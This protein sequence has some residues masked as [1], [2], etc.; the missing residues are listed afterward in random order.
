MTMT[1]TTTTTTTAIAMTIAMTAILGTTPARADQ[2]LA[3]SAGAGLSLSRL[4]GKGDL[5]GD[6]TLGPALQ[7]DGGY[8]VLPSLALGLHAGFSSGSSI[9][10][11]AD[12]AEDQFTY[13][14][15]ELGLSAQLAITS[16]LWA[17][18][19]LGLARLSRYGTQ[20]DRN[21]DDSPLSFG[22]TLGGDLLAYRDGHRLGAFARILQT[23]NYDD[24]HGLR[25]YGFGVAYRYW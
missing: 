8:R 10:Y 20:Y 4:A 13:T 15:T 17:A 6:Y 19:S 18:V 22:L 25:G 5:Q 21:T 2:P 16:R 14:T 24:S 7:L 12:A 11:V 23:S 9:D 1:M 3:V